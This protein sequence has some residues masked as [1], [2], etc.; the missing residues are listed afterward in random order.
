MHLTWLS[1]KWALWSGIVS[2]STHDCTF[3]LDPEAL[4]ES[5]DASFKKH[6]LSWSMCLTHKMMS[7]FPWPRRLAHRL[8]QL[9]E[10]GQLGEVL[11]FEGKIFLHMGEEVGRL[12]D[13]EM[14]GGALMD[15]GLYMIALSSWVYGGG[16]PEL[17]QASALL[18]KNGVDTT[19]SLNLR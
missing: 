14:G 19:G 18:H 15:I 2:S 11:Y 8:K 12:Y 9:I 17:L 4:G 1:V 10:S 5:F 7:H 16:K 6:I 13:P 3:D